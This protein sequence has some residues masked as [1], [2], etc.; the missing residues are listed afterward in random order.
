ME[1]LEHLQQLMAHGHC[2][3]SVSKVHNSR[4]RASRL[5]EA[6]FYYIKECVKKDFP[7]L[8]FMRGYMG[9]EAAIYGGFIDTVGEVQPLR[10]NAFIGDCD[11][12]FT[13]SQYNIYLCWVRHNSKLKVVAT[14]HCHLHIDCFENSSVEV[15]ISSPAAMVRIN[16]YGNSKVK[17]SGHTECATCTLH[18]TETYK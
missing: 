6:Y 3:E 1:R 14:D 16:Q 7:D 2:A 10:R 11:A 8:S 9:A 5:V 15:V 17:V 13:G 4:N 18:D 12:S